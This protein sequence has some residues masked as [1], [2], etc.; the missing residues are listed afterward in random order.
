MPRTATSGPRVVCSARWQCHVPHVPSRRNADAWRLPEIDGH[1]RKTLECLVQ[2]F[3]STGL[4]EETVRAQLQGNTQTAEVNDGF[5][6]CP[7]EIDD[8]WLDAVG[9]SSRPLRTATRLRREW[10]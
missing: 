8:S 6:F 1:E 5:R 9:C 2:D 4:D 7:I 3:R 10:T